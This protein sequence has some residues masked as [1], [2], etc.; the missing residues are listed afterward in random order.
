MESIF[1]NTRFLSSIIGKVFT[2]IT[3]CFTS[4]IITVALTTQI[5]HKIFTTGKAR[6]PKPIKLNF[7]AFL[8]F[9]LCEYLFRWFSYRQKIFIKTARYASFSR[10]PSRGL[11]ILVISRGINTS[12]QNIMCPLKRRATEISEEK[13]LMD[14]DNIPQY[15]KGRAVLP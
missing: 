7:F 9:F 4:W 3:L 13:W 11:N 1:S 2:T 14:F 5:S 10:L 8:C 15:V 6:V 12:L